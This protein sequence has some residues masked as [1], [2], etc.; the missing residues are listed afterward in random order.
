M[1][2]TA[3]TLERAEATAVATA[4]ILGTEEIPDTAKDAR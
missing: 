3:A 2:A 4:D 1:S